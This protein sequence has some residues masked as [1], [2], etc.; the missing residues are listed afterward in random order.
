MQI[1]QT[2]LVSVHCEYQIL[3]LVFRC[4]I[5]LLW[6]FNIISYREINAKYVIRS[7]NKNNYIFW[8]F[9]L[10]IEITLQWEKSHILVGKVSEE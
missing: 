6:Q 8:L 7:F 9:I 1:W 3:K 2:F 10:N 5:H 4:N